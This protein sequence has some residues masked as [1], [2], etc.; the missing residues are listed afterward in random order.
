MTAAKIYH[1]D[2]AKDKEDPAVFKEIIEAYE[3]LSDPI[4][5]QT[6]DLGL[7]N[8]AF[9]EQD[10]KNYTEDIQNNNHSN[11]FYQNK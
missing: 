1:P 2:V 6:Y 10:M 9:S 11:T 5:K 7:S 8:A 3:V 4:K